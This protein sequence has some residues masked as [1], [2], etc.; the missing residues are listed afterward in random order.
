MV[1]QG[2]E[3]LGGTDASQGA[4]PGQGGP[5]RAREGQASPGRVRPGWGCRVRMPQGGV[6]CV[7]VWDLLSASCIKRKDRGEPGLG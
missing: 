7:G 1:G 5:G 2:T 6:G 4:R 3:V